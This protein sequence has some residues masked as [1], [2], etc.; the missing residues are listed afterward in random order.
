LVLSASGVKRGNWLRK[1]VL[2]NDLIHEEYATELSVDD[3]AKSLNMIST[4]FH[5]HFKELTAS[6]PIQYVKSLRLHK[7]ILFMVQD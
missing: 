5:K 7:A 1:S 6:S 3:L 4:A 2:L